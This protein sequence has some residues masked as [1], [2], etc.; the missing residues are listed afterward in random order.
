VVSIGSNYYTY[1]Y[2]P[3]VAT[4]DGKYRKIEVRV[5][6]PGAH[7]S[8]RKGYYADDPDA[9]VHGQKTPQQGTMQVAMMRGGP[10]PAELVFKVRV[11]RGDSTTEQVSASSRPDANRMKPPYR[12]YKLD[13]LLDIHNVNMPANGDGAHQG[14]VEFVA[15]VYD[16][17]GELVNSATRV[18][19]LTLPAERYAQLLERGLP[20]S[21]S[22]EVPEKGEYFLR[23][24]VHDVMS[25]RVGAIEIPV[26]TLKSQ[27]ATTAR[28]DDNATAQ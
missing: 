20:F 3:P 8:Y 16:A 24:G 18:G 12:S 23:F 15:L 22:I 7:L 17:E 21:Q 2:K 19:H 6:Q 10:E 11:T 28:A 27:Q 26:A 14:S 13:A 1:S 25:D 4:W 5:N 9:D